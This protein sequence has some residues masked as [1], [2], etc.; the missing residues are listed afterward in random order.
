MTARETQGPLGSLHTLL[1][2]TQQLG[3]TVELTPLLALVA[4]AAC[5][6]VADDDGGD[7]G[8]AGAQQAGAVQ[9]ATDADD[10]AVV[11]LPV[12]RR[13]ALAVT[14]IESS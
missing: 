1:D 13:L 14:A 2:V 4:G 7:V 11:G 12:R 5:R 10:A 8:P 3:A 6:D 9:G